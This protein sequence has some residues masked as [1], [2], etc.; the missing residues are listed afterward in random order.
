MVSLTSSTFTPF[1]RLPSYLSFNPSSRL[2][3]SMDFLLG[4]NAHCFFFSSFF[5]FVWSRISSVEVE[6]EVAQTQVW[7]YPFRSLVSHQV[8]VVRL[9]RVGAPVPVTLPNPPAHSRF[10]ASLATPTP[11]QNPSWWPLSMR[12]PPSPQTLLN[13]SRTR[14]QPRFLQSLHWLSRTCE[15]SLDPLVMLY[16]IW[17]LVASPLIPRLF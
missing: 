1:L 6:A 3:F 2:I 8:R 10:Q 4:F 5:W 15:S 16:P 14:L 12:L 11:P 7:L 9:V 17:P 13:S